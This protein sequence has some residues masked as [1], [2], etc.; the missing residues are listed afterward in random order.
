M[1]LRLG[2]SQLVCLLLQPAA[3]AGQQGRHRG[4][5]R[6]RRQGE[7]RV[8]LVDPAELE[9]AE[10]IF[11]VE[12]A[13]LDRD[14]VGNEVPGDIAAD[15][16]ELVVRALRADADL[17][18]RDVRR[19]HARRRADDGERPGRAGDVERIG[20]GRLAAAVAEVD[21][22]AVDVGRIERGGGLERIAE[23]GGRPSGEPGEAEPVADLLVELNL[24][25]PESR[26]E[27]VEARFGTDVDA[28]EHAV[29]QIA[30][31]IIFDLDD[32]G[33]RLAALGGGAAERDR[34]EEVLLPGGLEP[35]MEQ[36]DG[37]ASALPG[38]GLEREGDAEPLLLVGQPA[39]ARQARMDVGR[40]RGF[41][42]FGLV[43]RRV[44]LARRCR[45]PRDI[46]I[47]AAIGGGGRRV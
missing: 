35:G 20:D 2:I 37:E 9:G 34:L 40:Q 15:G 36:V 18:R 4:E 27:L 29:E 14:L 3:E 8:V 33:L 26:V 22:V 11:A 43:G 47:A 12:A 24:V 16:G 30:V 13:G 6:S 21:R 1:A 41:I 32:A 17:R 25:L 23:P 31:G 44:G 46:G 5:R 7:D 28:V 38:L 19:G 10:L 45:E 39:V 42:I